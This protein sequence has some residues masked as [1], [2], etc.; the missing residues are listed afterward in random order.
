MKYWNRRAILFILLVV[1]TI[2][3]IGFGIGYLN[4][5]DGFDVVEK[6]GADVE[7]KPTEVIQTPVR[8]EKVSYYL[9]GEEDGNIKLYYVDGDETTEIKSEKISLD[10]LP[11]DDISLLSDGI[12]TETAD[13]ALAIWE[14]FIS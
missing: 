11:S 12:K 13:E 6:T 8:T 14:N 1:A 5:E 9:V 3:S 4:T 2:F 10:V 7:D